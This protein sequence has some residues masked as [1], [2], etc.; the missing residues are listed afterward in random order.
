MSNTQ[1]QVAPTPTIP[2][3]TAQDLPLPP[4]PQ[5]PR[6][7]EDLPLPPPKES[8]AKFHQQRQANELRRLYRH[9]HP[10]LRKNL[11]EAVAED[12]AEVLGAEEPTE[13]DVQC[14]R[15]IFENWRL[16]AIG[17]HEKPAAAREP[18]PSGDVQATSRRFEEGSFAGGTGQ[19]PAGPPPPSGADVRA[20]RRLFETKPLAELTGQTEE[21]RAPEAPAKEPEASG[22]VQGTRMLFETRPLDRLGSR[23]SA[24]E[25]PLELRSEIRELKGDVKKTVRLFQT[26]PLCAI[27]D[28]EG[29]IHEVKAVCREEIQ[30]HAVRSARWLFETRPLDAINRDPSQ[31]RLIRGI[32]LEEGARPDVSATRWI[33]E[34][35]PLDAIREIL[36]DEKDFQPS[37]DLLPPGPDVRQQRYLFETRALDTLKGEEEAVAE[38]PP[39]EEVVP[40]DVRST[41]WLFEM[42]PQDTPRGQVQVGHLQRVGPG[43]GEGLM[44]AHL[45]SDSFSALCLPPSAPQ[46]DGVKG[47]VKTFKNLFETLP[48]DSI[49]Q[50]EPSTPG[51]GSEVAGTD[52]AGQAQDTGSPVYAVQDG[53]GHLH[54]LTSV[55]REQVVGGDV[56]G[57]RWMFET[58]P[59]DQLGRSPSTIDVVRG[60]TRQEV[61]AGDVSTARWLFETQ[62]LEVIHQRE[63]QERQEEEGRSQAGPQPEAAPKGDVQT[64][65]WLFETCPMSELAEKQGSEATDSTAKAEAQ[66]CTWMF[67]PQTLDRPEGSRDQ[68]LQVCQ[69]RAGEGQTDRHVFEIEPLRA[70][71]GPC[72]RAPVR[73]CSHVEIPSGQVSR[74]K[75]VFQGLDAGKRE[76]QGSRAIPEPIPVGSVHK[77]TWLFENCPMGSL[78][79]ES[80][81]GGDLQ[82]EQPVG[83]SGSVPKRQETAIQGTLRTLHATPGIL[84][85]GGILMEARG[86]GELCLAKYVLPGPGQGPPHIWKEELVSSELPRIVRLVLSRPDVDQQGLLVQEDPAGHLRLRPMRLLGGSGNVDDLD[87]EFQQ[88]LACGLGTSVARTGL[89]MQETEQGLVSLTA[90]SLQPWLSSRAPERSSVQLLASCIDKGDLSGLHSLRWE[91]PADPVPVPASEEAQRLPATE[92]IIHVPP[93]DPSMEMGH[94]RGPGAAPGTPQTIA[95]RS[96]LAGKEKQEDCCAG[97]EGAEALGKSKGASTTSPGPGAADLQ[98]TMQGLRMATAE[99]QSLQQQVLNKPKQG[100]TPGAVSTP[101]QDGLPQALAAATGTAQSNTRPTAGGDPRIPA[102][103]KKVSGEQKVLPTGLP[104]GRVTIQDG[105]Y[106]AHPVRTCDL[107]GSVQPFEREHPPRGGETVCL[108]QASSPL[109][110][111]PGQSLGQSREEPGGCTQRAWGP[112]EKAM[113]EVS[114]QAA[115]TTLKAASSAH[116]TLTSGP[117]AAGDGLHSH[118]A[119]DPPPPLPAAVTGPDFPSQAH[120]DKDSS[121]AGQTSPGESQTKTPNLEPTFPPRKKPQLPPKPAHLGQIPPP[122]RLPKPSAPSP[123]SSQGKYKQGETKAATPQPGPQHGPS[124]MAPGPTKSQAMGSNVQ[125]PEPPKVSALNSDPTSPRHGPGTPGEKLM[126]CSQQGAP[127]SCETQQGSPQELQNLLSQVQALEKE[128]A[129]SV[130]VGALRRIFEAVP[131]LEGALQAPAAPHKPEASMEQAFGELTRVSMELSR[132]KKQTLTRLLS[133]EE[134]V[135]KALSKMSGLQPE[136]NTRGYPQGPLEDHGA[137][138]VS[139]MDSSGARP[140]CSGEKVRGQTAPRSQPEVTCHTEVQSQAKVKSHTE[141]RGPADSPAPSTRRME[142]LRE[143]AGIPPVSPS[144][145]DASSSPTF[146]SFKSAARKLPEA[147]SPGGSP[148][149]SVQS[150]HLAQDVSQAPLHQKGIRAKAGEIEVTQ[151][152][153]QP[154]PTLASA[155]TLPGAQKSVLEL[156]TGP[157]GSQRWEAMRT[158]TEQYTEA[159]QCGNALLT[160]STMATEQAEPSGGPGPHLGLQ[161]S[162]LLKPFLHSPAELSGHSQSAA[163]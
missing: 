78:A 80:I 28:A 71:G 102:A 137:Y 151:G 82:E 72:G 10:E 75:E 120:R 145:R 109:H 77:F 152:S 11:A 40:G 117:P 106:N 67:V 98:A 126:E 2:M 62:P 65:R 14:M 20:A 159:G 5:P 4:P 88:L 133:I 136:A 156:Q 110:E 39:K 143:D 55:S 163:Q 132:L 138:K 121:P 24:Q 22:D 29:A 68:H 37:P 35:Q 140:N 134:A 32:S 147:P 27:R 13:G 79:A 25:S 26:E 59:L 45:S 87:P 89:V 141:T 8:F 21:A 107:P 69:V 52:S 100:P 46:K 41:L 111:C 58:Q 36:V 9:I 157:G 49:G 122:Q 30:S 73:Y 1:T 85:R 81:R 115:E 153:G 43:Q 127:E 66:S 123:S 7:P 44:C 113:A 50:G 142:T 3:A 104:G 17:D 116:Y 76:D 118:N 161:A 148:A 63:R 57:Y 139:V 103:P 47:D 16:D 93:L 96:L 42:K 91:P 53:R 160:P 144:S 92:S 15:W 95:K 64:I 19:E 12:L 150:T 162:P 158:G 112:P 38:A 83:P 130:D 94:L 119:S 86:P 18:V 125:S 146:I 23:P 135:H 108:T 31:V 61:V 74:Q 84:H 131:Q 6:A 33:F 124:T 56:Q 129:S 48:L 114:P 105:V 70:S 149:V 154:G 101:F 128:A 155:G 90:Y 99:A 97:Q 54:A 60:I 34:T 51:N